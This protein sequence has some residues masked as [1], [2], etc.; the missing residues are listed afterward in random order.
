VTTWAWTWGRPE[1]NLNGPNGS[2][3]QVSHTYQSP[4]RSMRGLSRAISRDTPGRLPMDR[5]GT[6]HLLRR[7]FSV[8]GWQPC[9]GDAGPRPYYVDTYRRRLSSGSSLTWSGERR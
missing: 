1:P 6:V 9:A 2:T 7:P 5:Y 4:G 8:A 3:I